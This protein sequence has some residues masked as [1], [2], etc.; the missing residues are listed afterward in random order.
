MTVLKETHLKRSIYSRESHQSKMWDKDEMRWFSDVDLRSVEDISQDDHV[1]TITSLFFSIQDDKSAEDHRHNFEVE[2]YVN[3]ISDALK[4]KKNVCLARY[5]D[6]VSSSL[7]LTSLNFCVLRWT[8][9]WWWKRNLIILMFGRLIFSN[10]C[11]LLDQ[12]H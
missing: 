3:I 10:L 12:S 7:H 11:C 2:D 4:M 5:F 1:N 8:R 9:S 6:Q